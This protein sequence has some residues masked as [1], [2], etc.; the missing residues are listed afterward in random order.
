M[1]DDV[2][3]A[4]Q[5]HLGAIDE[6]FQVRQAL[7]AGGDPAGLSQGK[8]DRHAAAHAQRRRE[9]DAPPGGI[10]AQRGAA[11]AGGAHEGDGQR[12]AGM[13]NGQLLRFGDRFRQ[14]ET[15]HDVR[16]RHDQNHTAGRLLT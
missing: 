10:D 3:R 9:H 8:I 1:A 13:R 11:R 7:Q 6:G 15:T 16:Q 2:R 14:D 12:F 5:R 4:E